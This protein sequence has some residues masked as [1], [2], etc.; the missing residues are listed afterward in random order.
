MAEH[1]C[2][3]HPGSELTCTRSMPHTIALALIDS[4][5]FTAGDDACVHERT[6]ALLLPQKQRHGKQSCPAARK[7]H[8]AR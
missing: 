4:R 5:K 6:L 2:V 8:P 7:Q 3:Q 1:T